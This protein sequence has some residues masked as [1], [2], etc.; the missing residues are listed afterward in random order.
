M[1]KEKL[2]EEEKK[3][4]GGEM[5]RGRKT[6]EN[7]TVF[8]IADTLFL[9]GDITVYEL[10]II[11]EEP[12]IVR[13]TLQRK[14]F[15]EAFAEYA[16]RQKQRDDLG[17]KTA[18]AKIAV[19]LRD[20]IEDFL[21]KFSKNLMKKYDERVK[22]YEEDIPVSERNFVIK[23]IVDFQKE[24]D[25]D[26]L[27][28]LRL[29]FEF[30]K[31]AGAALDELIRK[32]E[33]GEIAVKIKAKRREY[34]RYAEEYTEE[35]RE[36][37]E[38]EFQGKRDAAKTAYFELFKKYGGEISKDIAEQFRADKI[39]D[40]PKFLKF[41]S[42][43]TSEA[44]RGDYKEY[45][46]L[47]IL[48]TFFGNSRL[49]ENARNVLEFIQ[50]INPEK[51]KSWLAKRQEEQ[52]RK[53]QQKKQF[54]QKNFTSMSLEQIIFE[55][56][57]NL[58]GNI[59][60]L[61]YFFNETLDELEKGNGFGISEEELKNGKKAAFEIYDFILGKVPMG[62]EETEDY[63]AKYAEYYSDDILKLKAK[64]GTALE[65][66]IDCVRTKNDAREAIINLKELRNREFASLQ[67]T[68]L[69]KDIYEDTSDFE[70][71]ARKT[72]ELT[73]EIKILEMRSDPE[74]S[75]ELN[76]YNKEEFSKIQEKKNRLSELYFIH[77]KITKDDFKKE[78]ENIEFEEE[79]FVPLEVLP[80]AIP[81]FKDLEIKYFA[82]EIGKE[83][84]KNE[85][86]KAIRRE[87]ADDLFFGAVLMQKEIKSL[88]EAMEKEQKEREILLSS[89]RSKEKKTTSDENSKN[90]RPN[91]KLIKAERLKEDIM[92]KEQELATRNKVYKKLLV[93]RAKLLKELQK[94]EKK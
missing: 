22:E 50:K 35:E 67:N 51:V 90:K 13:E 82:G 37:S 64:D 68:K 12:S 29:Y 2:K 75:R 53:K 63:L 34:K 71:T 56:S 65:Y 73:E 76:R 24:R 85:F 33:G 7:L 57:Y 45:G 59:K 25:A 1:E 3:K 86:R 18:G 38:K 42:Q 41:K 26:I 36:G 11:K 81:N 30:G 92:E 70:K 94:E 31:T 8:Q 84:Y 61:Y 20:E 23:N 69:T 91:R 62:D 46:D 43:I 87:K 48:K 44:I 5:E 78:L 52:E 16:E 32:I 79:I 55:Y 93:N 21:F 14:K 15:K 39:D 28:K 10:S 89:V 74:K 27:E 47:E 17:K 54:A 49:A 83:K 77:K 88:L 60:T 4:G 80:D 40:I 58:D 9:E 19:I 6:A 72:V 66:R